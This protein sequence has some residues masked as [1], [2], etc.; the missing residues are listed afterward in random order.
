VAGWSSDCETFD[1]IQQEVLSAL[2]KALPVDA[3]LL[4]L[5]GS[6]AAEEHPDVEGELLEAI[7][8][9]IGPAIPLV[10][11]LDLHAN[12]TSRMVAAAD[13]AGAVSLYPHVDIYE[14]GIRGAACS[15][16][17]VDGAKPTT[18]F[19]K[20][21]ASF[22]A[23]RPIPEL[24]TRH[25]RQFKRKVQGLGSSPRSPRRRPRHC[26]PWLDIPVRLGNGRDGQQPCARGIALLRA[27]QRALGAAERISAGAVH[28]G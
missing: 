23:R 8:K 1:W 22:P 15:G 14:T 9:L 21:P 13:A 7:R 6:M 18:A 24:A 16:I 2:T 3:V 20:V 28:R 25:E 12:I 26:Q 5:H 11:T 27:R 19:V 17:L 4:A 10:S